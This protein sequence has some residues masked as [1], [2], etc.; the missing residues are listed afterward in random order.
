MAR[1]GLTFDLDFR[2]ASYWVYGDARQKMRA[3][4]GSM[5]DGELIHQFDQVIDEAEEGGG[6]DPLTD[7]DVATAFLGRLNHAPREDGAVEIAHIQMF[8]LNCDYISVLAE[9]RDGRIHYQVTDNYPDCWS[10]RCSPESSERPLTFG[11]LIDL[12][13]TAELVSGG[14]PYYRG[15]VFGVLEQNL[16][17]DVDDELRSFL[18][19]TSAFYDGLELWYILECDSWCASKLC[20]DSDDTGGT[21]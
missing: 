9:W 16:D 13:D 6:V 2:P 10:Y 3:M 18:R 14:E 7:L 8:N 11:E 21:P 5:D 1:S 12:I 17:G 15:L 20:D 4:Q 19:V